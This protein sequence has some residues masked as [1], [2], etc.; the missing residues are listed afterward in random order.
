[1][2]SQ[3][4]WKI[5]LSSRKLKSTPKHPWPSTYHRKI[6]NLAGRLGLETG[7]SLGDSNLSYDAA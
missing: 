7:E 6:P 2:S 1:M 5:K 3:S 4:E